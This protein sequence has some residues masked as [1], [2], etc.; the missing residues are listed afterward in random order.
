MHLQVF[1]IIKVFVHTGSRIFGK[2]CLCHILMQFCFLLVVRLVQI[3]Q[4]FQLLGF[5]LEKDEAGN[6]QCPSALNFY[7]CYLLLNEAHLRASHCLRNGQEVRLLGRMFDI[8]SSECTGSLRKISVRG[9]V[10]ATASA[11]STI[12]VT[13]DRERGREEASLAL[14]LCFKLKRL[15]FFPLRT[16]GG[17]KHSSICSCFRMYA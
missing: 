4:F 16:I 13:S 7:L 6:A 11:F 14:V 10:P 9:N 1:V 17:R 2:S 3:L 15:T 5:L 8:V 12:I